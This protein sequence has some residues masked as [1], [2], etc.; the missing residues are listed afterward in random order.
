MDEQATTNNDQYPH[1]PEF[2]DPR[3]R[4]AAVAAR[5]Q[6][7]TQLRPAPRTTMSTGQATVFAG[8]IIHILPEVQYQD[9]VA[10][11][12]GRKLG[13]LNTEDVDFV[14]PEAPKAVVEDLTRPLADTE[15]YKHLIT[16]ELQDDVAPNGDDAPTQ[17][18]RPAA[19]GDASNLAANIPASLDD[20]PVNLTVREIDALLDHLKGIAVTLQQAKT[21]ARREAKAQHPALARK[22]R[23]PS[24]KK[25]SQ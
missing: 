13:W 23:K 5:K 11:R 7:S 8:D 20:I 4:E 9:W 3:W 14:D 2:G 16:K 17:A 1:L 22:G 18:T 15:S 25:S 24:S 12:V 6:R 10:A 19:N 21:R